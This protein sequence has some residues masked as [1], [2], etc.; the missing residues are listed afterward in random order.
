MCSIQGGLRV[1]TTFNSVSDIQ[2]AVNALTAA[3]TDKNLDD[4]TKQQLQQGLDYVQQNNG[5]LP[6]DALAAGIVSSPENRAT[7]ASL[8]DTLQAAQ[9]GTGIYG[10]RSV[11]QAQR[12][13]VQA[14]PG[15]SQL[16]ASKFGGGSATGSGGSSSGGLGAPGGGSTSAGNTSSLAPTSNVGSFF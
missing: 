1:A 3:T 5:G 13:I 4:I 12:N 7:L 10:V 2:N 15:R 16:I 11:N 6:S 14:M 9:T 8:Y